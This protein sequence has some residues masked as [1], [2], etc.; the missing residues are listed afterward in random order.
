MLSKILIV[1]FVIVLVIAAGMIKE[2]MREKDLR[3]WTEQRPGA[4]LHWPFLPGEHEDEAPAL[5]L[6]RAL[7]PE[8]PLSWGAAVRAQDEKGE[9]WFFEFRRSPMANK[10]SRWYVLIAR[11]LDSAETARR[12]LERLQ[13]IQ[14]D[15]RAAVHGAWVCQERDGLLSS[16]L[17]DEVLTRSHSSAES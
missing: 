13:E 6:V 1:L 14:A 8:A 3:T 17:L 11:R 15:V 10:S 7:R 2:R 5:E 12:Y 4:R 9:V 16:E